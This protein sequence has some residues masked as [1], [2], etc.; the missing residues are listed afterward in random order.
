LVFA[1]GSFSVLLDEMSSF[2]RNLFH[3]IEISECGSEEIEGTIKSWEFNKGEG[4]N[5]STQ[6]SAS[7]PHSFGFRTEKPTIDV[8]GI[9]RILKQTPS[10]TIK[11]GQVLTTFPDLAFLLPDELVVLQNKLEKQ[12]CKLITEPD[13]RISSIGLITKV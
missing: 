3:I 13:G 10:Q 5:R 2:T 1:A 4:W 8:T 12:H 7:F 9:T 6:Q 11:N